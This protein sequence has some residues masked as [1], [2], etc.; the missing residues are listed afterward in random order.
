MTR[1]RIFGSK[2]DLDGDHVTTSLQRRNESNN[3]NNQID[4]RGND[5]IHRR[6]FISNDVNFPRI[7]SNIQTPVNVNHDGN[8]PRGIHGLNIRNNNFAHPTHHTLLPLGDSSADNNTLAYTGMSL[9]MNEEDILFNM[10]YFGGTEATN[11]QNFGSALN[12]MVEETIA[13]HSEN[14]TPYKLKP[15]SSSAI[16]RLLPINL[17]D[18]ESAGSKECAICTDPWE[19]NCKI[20]RL[21]SCNHCFHDECILHWLELVCTCVY[22]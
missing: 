15:A 13:A 21:H 14:N 22:V 3:Y 4:N 18:I 9:G 19:A 2:L 12:A 7:V 17:G 20:I 16:S 6:H 5:D 8:R 11:P 10:M 1:T